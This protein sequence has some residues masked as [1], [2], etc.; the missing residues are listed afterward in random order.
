MTHVSRRETHTGRNKHWVI[1]DPTSLRG[2][3]RLVGIKEMSPQTNVQWH[4]P[5]KH[6]E[7]RVKRAPREND[8][9]GPHLDRPLRASFWG[10][11]QSPSQWQN[12]ASNLKPVL[13]TSFPSL[14]K[15]GQSLVPLMSVSTSWTYLGPLGPKGATATP[16]RLTLPPSFSVR[17]WDRSNMGG[18]RWDHLE[19]VEW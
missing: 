11:L 2:V 1:T 8:R 7:G 13:P 6:D 9:G 18:W 15:W 3:H 16:L 17:G 19:N 10:S 5:I 14:S 12:Q 4:I